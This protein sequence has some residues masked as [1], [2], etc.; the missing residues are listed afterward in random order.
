MRNELGVLV[1]GDDNP[2]DAL[3]PRVHVEGVGLLLHVLSRAGGG[4]LS[5]GPGEVGQEF[6]DGAALEEGEAAEVAGFDELLRGFRGVAEDLVEGE[7]G[8]V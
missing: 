3:G 2:R 6:A 8:L 4:A 5:H 7:G 1:I